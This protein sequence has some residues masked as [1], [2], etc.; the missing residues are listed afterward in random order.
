MIKIFYTGDDSIKVK[1]EVLKAF[2]FV[3]K[4]FSVKTPDIIVRVHNN[5]TNFDKQLKTKTEDW[6]V[7][8]ASDNNEIDILSP[9]AIKNESSHNKIEFSPILKHEFT[10]IFI[11]SF[12]KGRII[13]KW[14]E[15]GLAQYVAKQY[16]SIK[17]IKN[18]EDDFCKKMGTPTGW[19]K[20]VDSFA[21]PVS[22]LFVYFLIKT[23]S[24]KKIAELLL[25]LD[26]EYKYPKFKKTFLKIYKKSLAEIE[27]EFLIEINK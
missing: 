12:A 9:L 24:F 13:P 8:N 19:Y 22:A 11:D 17:N 20:R 14:L 7:A 6:C 18:I 3:Y 16:K 25:S 4:Y 1:N 10:H 2:N 27:K 23:Y 26:K 5:R 15:E 21:Y